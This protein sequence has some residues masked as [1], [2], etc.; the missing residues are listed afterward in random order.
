MKD[1]LDER[2]EW[3][4]PTV[5]AAPVRMTESR[6]FDDTTEEFLTNDDLADVDPE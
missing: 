6:G 4:A 3:V 2:K 5:E 1:N